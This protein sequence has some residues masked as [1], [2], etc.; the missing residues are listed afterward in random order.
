[1]LIRQNLSNKVYTRE[2]VRIYSIDIN[3]YTKT[4]R[5][6]ATTWKQASW[7][8][9]IAY[10]FSKYKGSFEDT[11]NKLAK[12]SGHMTIQRRSR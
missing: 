4:I 3:R 6:K 9:Y 10:R 7:G 11:V 2:P 1:M 5:F 12:Y 8:G